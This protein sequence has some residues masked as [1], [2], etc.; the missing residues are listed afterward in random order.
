V[1]FLSGLTSFRI[2][3][4]HPD[5]TPFRAHEYDAGADLRA[6][7]DEPVVIPPG[8][9]ALIPTGVH[10]DQACWQVTFLKDRS[11]L[12]WK[13]GI[14]V[15]G[16]VID[17]PFKGEIKV[18]LFNSDPHSAFVVNP[19]DRIAQMVLLQT[20]IYPFECISV[21]ELTASDR[22]SAGFGST[23]V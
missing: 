19:K 6:R 2:A 3:V 4:T 8:H 20:F 23:G 11:G 17:S 15:L 13:Y 5:Y 1:I 21:E 10:V 7:V 22:G 18:V 9:R 12:A 16:G 14:T